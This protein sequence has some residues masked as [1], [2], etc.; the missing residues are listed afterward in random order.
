MLHPLMQSLKW[1]FAQVPGASAVQHNLPL[2]QHGSDPC[3]GHPPGKK[4]PVHSLEA[5]TEISA[6]QLPFLALPPQ[7][8][9]LQRASSPAASP[10]PA[11]VEPVP[12]R[13]CQCCLAAVPVSCPRCH[14]PCDINPWALAC[15][16]PQRG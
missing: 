11:S 5:A 4:Q 13:P 12:L 8:C 1:A 10:T 3:L 9:G 14:Q 15:L 6:H 16:R 7:H 2:R